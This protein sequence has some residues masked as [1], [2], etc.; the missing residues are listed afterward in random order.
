MTEAEMIARIET[1][2]R[3]QQATTQR[4]RWAAYVPHLGK[5]A[6]AIDLRPNQPFTAAQLRVALQNM[7][8]EI[9]A[10]LETFVQSLTEEER[11]RVGT[12]RPDEMRPDSRA[13]YQRWASLMQAF[14]VFLGEHA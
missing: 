7:P 10:A 1:L 3:Q 5:V 4:L 14:A 13:H 12:L 9:M 8:P 2:E 6:R 11:G